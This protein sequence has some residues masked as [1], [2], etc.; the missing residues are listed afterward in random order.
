MSVAGLPADALALLLQRAVAAL[1]RS[2][3]L[4]AA[5]LAELRRGR[6]GSLDVDS[7]VASAW[8]TYGDGAWSVADLRRAGLVDDGNTVR[9]GHLLGSIKREGG[10]IGR[11]RLSALDR[12]DR[13]GRIWFLRPV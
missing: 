7:I 13:N 6:A 10:R 2:E 1:E 3:A 5:T 12:A 11:F 8:E 4:Q 9:L